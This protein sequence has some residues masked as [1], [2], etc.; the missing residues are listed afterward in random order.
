VEKYKSQKGIIQLVPLLIIFS[1][2]VGV[3]AFLL[4]KTSALKKTQET[5]SNQ[6][7]E[8]FG[9]KEVYT[10]PFEEKKNPFDYLNE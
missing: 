7:D 3:V 5:P 6:L 4:F 9:E 1:L 2:L 8:V 10:N